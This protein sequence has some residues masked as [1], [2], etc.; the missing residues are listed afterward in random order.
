MIV[1]GEAIDNEQLQD[2]KTN[3]RIWCFFRS[4][5]AQNTLI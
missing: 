1:H 3:I 2:D 5:I 4:L